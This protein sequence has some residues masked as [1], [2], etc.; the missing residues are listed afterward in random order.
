MEI[1]PEILID[2]S[3]LDISGLFARLHSKANVSR[4]NLLSLFVKKNLGEALAGDRS[5]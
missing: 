5:T 3:G 2:V 4:V 1:A